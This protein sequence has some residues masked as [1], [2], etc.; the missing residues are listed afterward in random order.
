MRSKAPQPVAPTREL[1][2]LFDTLHRDLF[3]VPAAITPGKDA[4]LLV[5]LWRSHGEQLTCDLMRDFFAT[6]DRFIQQAGYTVPLFISQVGK[7][8]AHRFAHRL[9][10]AVPPRLT[11]VVQAAQALS[12]ELDQEASDGPGRPT[13]AVECL[14]ASGGGHESIREGRQEDDAG[15]AADV[16]RGQFWL[17]DGRDRRRG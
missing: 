15:S 6:T 13:S 1:L 7:L 8:I 16:P 14:D 3:G 5:R 10:T 17:L 9:P 2:T 4:V 11:S 12:D